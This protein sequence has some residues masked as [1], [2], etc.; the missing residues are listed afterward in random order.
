MNGFLVPFLRSL[1][2]YTKT[3]MVY[4][5]SGGSWLVLGYALQTLTGLILSVAFA[6]LLPKEAFGTYQFVLSLAA[7]VGVFTL[8]G[9]GTALVRSVAK[10][11]TGTLRYGVR[12]QLAWSLGMIAVS[13]ALSLYYYLNGNLLLS[14]ALLIIGACQPFITGFGLYK[15]HLQG[16]QRFGESVAI[17]AVQRLVPFAALLVAVFLTDDPLLLIFVYFVSNA[18]SLFGAYLFVVLRHKLP[19]T[20]DPEF[21]KY[22]KHLSVMESLAEIAAAADK[23]LVWA[24][25]GAAP[26]AAYALAQ[27]PVIHMQNLF[28]FVRSLAFPKLAQKE[29]A[30]LKS[31]LP[32]MM[33]RYF[34]IALA[35]VLTYLLLAP[36]LFTLLFPAY[37][38]AVAYSQLLALVVLGVPR[39]LIGQS[40]AAHERTKELYIINLSTP[41]LRVVL[42]CVLLPLFGIWGAIAA[43]LATEL[44]IATA[45]LVLFKRA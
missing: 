29:F 26:L 17:E 19:L 42:L 31:A 34:F 38:E 15:W 37:P 27:L 7:I 24:F 14:A 8:T 45:Q 22:S 1:E 25:L 28:G 16:A 4:L 3:D 35:A 18:L 32:S 40:F 6:N 2:R 36:F 41:L 12:T 30:E 44:Y 23:V 39:S 13:G 9:V 20:V 21:T 10:G 33:A 43:V 5:A 11:A